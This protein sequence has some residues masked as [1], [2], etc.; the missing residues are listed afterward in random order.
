[1]FT[2]LT[3]GA[4]WVEILDRMLVKKRLKFTYIVS[5]E[6]RS[7]VTVY[8]FVTLNLSCAALTYRLRLLAIS[9][10]SLICIISL[11]SFCLPIFVFS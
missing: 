5:S 3:F 1:M 4:L 2:I 6:F 8:A 10:L 7:S 11:L 9:V